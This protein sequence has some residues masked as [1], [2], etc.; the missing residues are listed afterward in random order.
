MELD[1]LQAGPSRTVVVRPE[2]WAIAHLVGE[3]RRIAN[4]PSRASFRDRGAAINR[5]VDLRGA[6]AELFLWK[7]VRDRDSNVDAYM[8]NHL[9]YENKSGSEV[10]GP[11]L[12]FRDASGIAHGIDVKSHDCAPHKRYFAINAAKHEQLRGQ[13]DAYWCLLVPSFAKTLVLADLVPYAAVTAWKLETWRYGDPAR[14]IPLDQ[15][16]QQHCSGEWVSIP[17]LAKSENLYSRAEILAIANSSRFQS[18][19]IERLPA[20][21]SFLPQ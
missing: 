12:V 9:L 7:R 10:S 4:E 16:I 15:F 21:R 1:E 19:A 8:R 20:L 14:V 11:D 18:A 2:Q 3:A 6:F 13:C 17:N 5:D